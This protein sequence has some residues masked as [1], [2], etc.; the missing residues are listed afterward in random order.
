MYCISTTRT[1]TF[2]EYSYQKGIVSDNANNLIRDAIVHNGEVTGHEDFTGMTIYQE[3]T[4]VSFPS[5]QDRENF[6]AEFGDK[7][8]GCIIDTQLTPGIVPF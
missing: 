1:I 3:I 2:G 4:G 6:C 7:Y 5:I 8:H